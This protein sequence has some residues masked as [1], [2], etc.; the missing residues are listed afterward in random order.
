MWDVNEMQTNRSFQRQKKQSCHWLTPGQRNKKR[1]VYYLQHVDKSHPIL[2]AD[3]F[4]DVEK[5]EWLNSILDSCLLCEGSLALLT[6]E[7]RVMIDWMTEFV[8]VCVTLVLPL[9]SLFP[10]PSMLRPLVSSWGCPPADLFHFFQKQ[11][12][13]GL[14]VTLVTVLH[15]DSVMGHSTA[16]FARLL[17]LFQGEAVDSRTVSS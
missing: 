5:H 1:P 10:V 7:K 8:C 13:P 16:D 3:I 6:R 15:L 11:R 12:S 17:Q 4:R 2:G 9:W 14:Q